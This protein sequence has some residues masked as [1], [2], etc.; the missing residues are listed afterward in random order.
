MGA[1]TKRLVRGAAASAER[2]RPLRELIG[3]AVPIDHLAVATFDQIR[4]VLLHF[5]RRHSTPPRSHETFEPSRPAT[6]VRR[7][8]VIRAVTA[9]STSGAPGGVWR[10]VMRAMMC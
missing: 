2:E 6:C 5:V 7:P 3:G 8:H 10:A 9:R 4:T 1:V